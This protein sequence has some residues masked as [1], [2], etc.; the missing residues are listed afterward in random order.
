MKIALACDHGGLQL[1]QAVKRHLEELGH[2]VADFG[3]H[4]AESCDYPD[5]AAE[6]ARAVADGRCQMGIVI[7]TTGIGVSMA[8]NKIHG[9]R[10]ALVSDLMSARLTRQ[11]NDA[12]MMALGAGVVGEKLAL[13]LT[14]AF[15]SASFEGGRHARRVAKLM[16]LEQ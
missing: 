14:D 13:E 9:V 10:C 16:A 11:H 15:L 6:A 1:K 2:Q 12:N 3:T 4:T 5:Y 8:A 7:C